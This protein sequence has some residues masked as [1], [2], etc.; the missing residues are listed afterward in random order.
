MEQQEYYRV[1]IGEKSTDFYLSR[2]HLFD[3]KGVGPSWNWP[4]FL[5]TFYWLLHRKMQFFA[6][7]Y[8]LLPLPLAAIDGIIFPGNDVAVAAISLLY[9]AAAFVV[10]PR[11][12]NALYYR[13]LKRMIDKAREESCDKEEALRVITAAGGTNSIA[14]T[15]TASLVLIIALVVVAVVMEQVLNSGV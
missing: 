4:A 9:L 12:A 15:I 3:S 7:L 14:R 5:V 2:F 11:Y 8:V 1:A 13:Q 6:L 10:L